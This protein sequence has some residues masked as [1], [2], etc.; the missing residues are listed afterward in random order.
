MANL[1]TNA[2]ELI[3]E[4]LAT[5]T[6]TIESLATKD[7][8]SSLINNVEL[9]F[10]EDLLERDKK[11]MELEDKLNQLSD[12]RYDDLEF[13][14]RLSDKLID[15]ENKLANSEAK[16]ETVREFVQFESDSSFDGTEDIENEKVIKEPLDMLII[17][18][19]IGRHLNVDLINPG[20]KNK[21]ICRPGAMIEEIQN[22]LINIES[23]YDIATLVIHVMTNHIPDEEPAEIAKEMLEFL[24]DI[25]LNMPNTNVFVSLVLPKINS[26]WLRG[27]NCLNKKIFDAHSRYGFNVIQHP[28]FASTGHINEALLARDLIHLSRDGVKQ[29]GVDIK[30]S[31]RSH[32][33]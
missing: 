22:A 28:H 5:L 32:S 12:Q 18:D 20:G 31:L 33:N 23:Q 1:T 15:L 13:A 17:S 14:K 25:K 10:A 30:R 6:E 8:I 7:D 3:Q 27:I 21:L 11:I 16:R 9:K 29:L 4:K 2:L 19:S 26:F 24:D